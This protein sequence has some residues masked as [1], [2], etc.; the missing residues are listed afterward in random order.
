MN[1]EKDLTISIMGWYGNDNAGDEAVLAGILEHLKSINSIS[2]INVFSNKPG[3]TADLH[4][5]NGLWTLPSSVFEALNSPYLWGFRRSYLPGLLALNKTDLC[6]IG[7]GGIIADH[8]PQLIDTWCGRIKSALSRSE[9][10]CLY[11]VGVEP[12]AHSSSKRKIQEIFPLLDLITVR[13]VESK[14]VLEECNI[15]NVYVTADPAFSLQLDVGTVKTNLGLKDKIV[16]CP[17]HRFKN[18]D[19]ELYGNMHRDFVVNLQKEFPARRVVIGSMFPADAFLSKYLD[20]LPN[21]DGEVKLYKLHPNKIIQMFSQADSIVSTRLH[22]CILGIIANV[23]VCPIVYDIKV[24]SFASLYGIKNITTE[25]GDGVTWA[26]NKDTGNKLF[27][28]FINCK[29]IDIGRHR[30][31]LD[32]LRKKSTDQLYQLREL[33]SRP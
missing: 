13:D 21:F 32:E 20:D 16:L 5:V 9:K 18:K 17:V 30:E 14:G 1:A 15:S 19:E 25:F 3:E 2:T 6:I 27:E 23:S 28:N 26:N 22:G 24:M 8:N 7:G 11:G 31:V 33:V 4:H 12:L 29:K 10:V